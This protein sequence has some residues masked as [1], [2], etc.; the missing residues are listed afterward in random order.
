MKY[1]WKFHDQ[2]SNLVWFLR[3]LNCISWQAYFSF[4]ASI[5][6]STWLSW[7][8]YRSVFFL[9]Y[10]EFWIASFT[11]SVLEVSIREDCKIN[12]WQNQIMFRNSDEF[13]SSCS[14]WP[15]AS[16]SIWGAFGGQFGDL[17]LGDML[18]INFWREIGPEG[19]YEVR[20]WLHISTIIVIQEHGLIPTESLVFYGNWYFWVFFWELLCWVVELWTIWDRQNTFSTLNLQSN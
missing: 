2:N 13:K 15:R 6:C 7:T 5:F 3:G 19:S 11:S 17:G 14:W 12:L 9:I 16:G 1:L 10:N 18:L 8:S 20:T 4:D